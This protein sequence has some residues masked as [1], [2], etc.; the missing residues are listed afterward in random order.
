MSYDVAVTFLRRGLLLTG[1]GLVP[2]I[3]LAT[4]MINGGPCAGLG[5]LA[6]AVI[7]FTCLPIGG[8]MLL[9]ALVRRVTGSDSVENSH[10]I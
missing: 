4:G 3:M 8:N 5:L 9:V 10:S 1:I 2:L 6:G 7:M